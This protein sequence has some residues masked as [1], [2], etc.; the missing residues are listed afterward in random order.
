MGN[1]S[2]SEKFREG[3]EDIALVCEREATERIY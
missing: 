2:G 1:G 3:E